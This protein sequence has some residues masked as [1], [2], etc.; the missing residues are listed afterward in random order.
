[1]PPDAGTPNTVAPQTPPGPQN[2]LEAKQTVE[3]QQVDNERKEAQETL[4]KSMEELRKGS[5]SMAAFA[6]VGAMLAALFVIFRRRRPEQAAVD[7]TVETGGYEARAQDH[8]ESELKRIADEAAANEQRGKDL[9]DTVKN[10]EEQLRKQ[11]NAGDSVALQIRRDLTSAQEQMAK[12]TTDRAQLTARTVHLK[13]EQGRRHGMVDHFN[14]QLDAHPS[15]RAQRM[16][17]QPDGT[18]EVLLR[19][20]L[21]PQQLKEWQAMQGANARLNINGTTLTLTVPAAF[22]SQWSGGTADAGRDAREALFTWLLAPGEQQVKQEEQRTKEAQGKDKE[23][24]VKSKENEMKAKAEK[25]AEQL[26]KDQE[27]KQQAMEKSAYSPQ[28]FLRLQPENL[29]QIIE[30]LVSNQ[31]VSIRTSIRNVSAAHALCDKMYYE[32]R[33]ASWKSSSNASAL[34]WAHVAALREADT[35]PMFHPKQVAEYRAKESAAKKAYEDEQQRTKSL[36]QRM[37]RLAKIKEELWAEIQ[38][39]DAVVG[40]GNGGRETNISFTS[41]RSTPISTESTLAARELLGVTVSISGFWPRVEMPASVWR[42]TPDGTGP[43]VTMIM[44]IAGGQPL[45]PQE[46][47]ALAVLA[48]ITAAVRRFNRRAQVAQLEVDE[49]GRPFL[50][51]NMSSYHPQYE[52]VSTRLVA[53]VESIVTMT[54]P[55][56]HSRGIFRFS[57]AILN[58]QILDRVADAIEGNRREVSP[59]QAD[60]EALMILVEQLGLH[61]SRLGYTRE[62][63]A[64]LPNAIV[65][66]KL[67]EALSGR[68]ADNAD[69]MHYSWIYCDEQGNVRRKVNPPAEGQI[70]VPNWATTMRASPTVGAALLAGIEWNTDANNRYTT[71]RNQLEALARTSVVRRVTDQRQEFNRRSSEIAVADLYSAV[72]NRIHLRIQC[73]ENTLAQPDD[74]TLGA[75]VAERFIGFTVALPAQ[76]ALE[77]VNLAGLEIPGDIRPSAAV[78]QIRRRTQDALKANTALLQELRSMQFTGTPTSAQINRINNIVTRMQD[79]NFQDINRR[80]EWTRKVCWVAERGLE[81]VDMAGETFANR[82]PIAGPLLYSTLRNGVGMLAGEQI[83]NPDGS[84]RPRDWSDF[85]IN[86]ATSLIP[87]DRIAR[88]IPGVR[89]VEAA[90]L[91]FLIRHGTVFLARAARRHAIESILNEAKDRLKS[92]LELV[93]KMHRDGRSWEEIWDAVSSQEPDYAGIIMSVGLRLFAGG[94]GD[95]ASKYIGSILSRGTQLVRADMRGVTE[96]VRK[97]AADRAKQGVQK[98]IQGS[99]KLLESGT[100]EVMKAIADHEEQQ[101]QL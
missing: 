85:G 2:A 74:L 98:L 75:R 13:I 67:I 93:A 33:D 19:Q 34:G 84:Y 78:R 51:L 62:M 54:G 59:E 40:Y 12:L 15:S 21:S 61:R 10:L 9:Q 49:N 18:V 30:K 39:R 3:V 60:R 76:T 64:R 25:D 37:E 65:V 14:T 1:M 8:P 43:T 99:P 94:S 5:D 68:T 101:G 4:R 82:V 77:L 69:F 36:T 7:P 45:T 24:Q 29:A 27:A 83:R 55:P 50:R 35:A 87:G 22:W 73:F 48:P 95:A 96:W 23:N 38:R 63:C 71:A 58:P 47:A 31:S 80:L 56:E 100:Q 70:L 41:S 20:P 44:K 86:V 72:E 32:A 91:R 92:Q 90:S 88:M 17:L 46:E 53:A 16:A 97:Q 81:Y 6:A 66:E 52:E 26:R 79:V 57:E 42:E 28:E 89:S 11:P